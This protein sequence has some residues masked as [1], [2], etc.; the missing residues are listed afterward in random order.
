[1]TDQ[2]TETP[3]VT[4]PEGDPTQAASPPAQDGNVNSDPT[5]AVPEGV[6]GRIDTL[7]RKRREAEE[8]AAYWR[9]RAEAGS[10]PGNGSGSVAQ[11][12]TP[13]PEPAPELDPNDFD[14]DA[15]YLKAVAKQ[16]KDDIKAEARVAEEARAE[17]RRK[18]TINASAKEARAKYTDFDTV[19]LSQGHPVTETMFEAA[20]GDGLGEVL[21]H[22]GKNPTEATRIANLPKTQQIKEIGKIEVR[23][24]AGAPPVPPVTNAPAPPKSVGGGGSPPSAAKSESEMS[25]VELHKKWEAERLRKLGVT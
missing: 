8:Q 11:G 10:A 13:T 14:S 3:G 16:A 19:A 12:A 17:E 2:N 15:D 21:Y 9:G 25:R 1:M 4:T 5:P 22:L 18:A 24:S 20:M 7:T 6:Q 23:L